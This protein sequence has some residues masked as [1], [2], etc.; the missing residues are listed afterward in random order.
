MTTAKKV[1]DQNRLTQIKAVWKRTAA[2]E[3]GSEEP[4][5]GQLLCFFALTFAFSWLFWVSGAIIFKSIDPANAFASP[6]FVMLQTLGA[7]G[8]SLVAIFLVRRLYGKEKLKS[9][10]ER[11][12]IWRVS[13]RWYLAAI[14]LTPSIAAASIGVH[15]IFASLRGEALV[16]PP[17]SPLGQTV[18]ELGVVGLVF[19]LPVMFIG[20]IP[21]SPL[22]EEA[23]WRGFALPVLQG[24]LNAIASSLILGLAW[25]AWHLPL[26][27]SYGDPVLAYFLLIVANTILITW[28]FNNTGGSLLLAMLFHASLN[29]SFSV[30][31][32]YQDD[33]VRLILTWAVVFVVVLGYGGKDLSPSGRF[34]WR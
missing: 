13:M 17:G 21:S 24:R 33:L 30:L 19:W 8:P 7:A 3:R 34:R 10:L 12:R 5:V 27:I 14:L 1:R 18:G 20:Q 16:L 15:A 29:I 26:I 2:E 9:L 23:G 6:G 28:V 22:L 11:F 32:I 31:E 4:G 25:G